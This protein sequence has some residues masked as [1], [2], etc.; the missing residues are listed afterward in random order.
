M[1]RSMGVNTL[2]S[3]NSPV[4]DAKGTNKTTCKNGQAGSAAANGD[5]QKEFKDVFQDF[6]D[7][8]SEMAEKIKNNEMQPKIKT[9]AAEYTVKDW[10]KLMKTVDKAID[11]I[12]EGNEKEK[13][14]Q[15]EI[16]KKQAMYKKA[17]KTYV[18]DADFIG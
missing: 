4:N 7:M 9:G 3:S 16:R 14:K 6:K 2:N 11:A 8:E 17:G 13:E 18:A 10:N 15:E 12:K 5:I 1:V